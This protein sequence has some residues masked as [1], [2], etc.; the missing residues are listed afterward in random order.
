MRR[1]RLDT[2][3]RRR[4]HATALVVA[5]LAGAS[6]C[7]FVA[8]PAD[9]AAYSS[10]QWGWQVVGA[11]TAWRYGT[12]AGIKIG[13]V[14]TGVD[15]SQQDLADKVVAG[16]T[17]LSDPS[18]GCADASQD[19]NGADD[20]GHGTHVAG[21]AAASGQYGVTGMAPSASLVVAKV[22]DCDGSGAYQDVVSGI[23]WAVQQGAKV[24]NLSLGDAA[25][26]GIDTSNIGGS[27]LGQALQAA[28][29]A[30]VIPVIAAGNNSDGPV[31]CAVGCLGDANYSGVPA[32]VVA[33]TGS[34][35]NG[36][37]DELAS[38]S[39][40]VNEAEWGV[41]APGGDDPNGPT[42][43][44]CGEYDQYEILSTYWASGDPTG[45]YATDEGT[46]MATPFVTGTLA[47]LLGRG[48]SPLK[49]VQ[50]LLDTADHNLSCGSD[51]SGLIDAA[52]AM[53]AA[54][55]PAATPSSRGATSTTTTPAAPAAASAPPVPTGTAG[56]AP[57]STAPADPAPPTS[58]HHTTLHV[59]ALGAHSPGGADQHGSSGWWVVLPLAVGLAGAAALA[60]A[61][62]RR[63]PPGRQTA[64]SPPPST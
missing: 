2:L 7:A 46:S 3:L 62:R 47:D 13:I 59:S 12:G 60:M 15:R 23:D 29:N 42:T 34:P 55:T 51:C 61:G 56:Q 37:T 14:D 32:V 17:F 45:C 63:W 50:D 58:P 20:N 43:P 48:L 28:W 36:E 52:A 4:R 54:A 40:G 39:N 44:S 27:P 41:A 25:I 1:L 8:A 35:V 49:A 6:A 22:L 24:I 11:Q 30:G 5:A 18:S 33:A 31:G 57:S 10:D 16:T 38:Y 21:I 53:Q 9:A 64:S 26:A 19:P